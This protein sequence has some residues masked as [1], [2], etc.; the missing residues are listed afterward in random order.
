MA[1]TEIMQS[2]AI[3]KHDLLKPESLLEGSEQATALMLAR[4]LYQTDDYLQGEYISMSTGIGV[5]PEFHALVQAG[6]SGAL[7]LRDVAT[8]CFLA[9]RLSI[10]LNAQR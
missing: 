3:Q 5:A 6:A 7:S 8:I 4:K 2:I 9:G 1:M 10:A